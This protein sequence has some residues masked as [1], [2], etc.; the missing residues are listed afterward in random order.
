MAWWP[1]ADEST[2]QGGMRSLYFNARGGE[3]GEGEGR[4]RDGGETSVCRAVPEKEDLCEERE[5]TH[6][7]RPDVL[8]PRLH[9]HI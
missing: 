1:T 3:E 5:V 9:H 8:M 7:V 2:R 6:A 4:H